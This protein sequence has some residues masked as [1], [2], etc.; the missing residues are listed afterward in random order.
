MQNTVYYLTLEMQR[1]GYE[2]TVSGFLMSTGVGEN[3][4]QWCAIYVG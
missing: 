4:V 1:L 2:V 3:G